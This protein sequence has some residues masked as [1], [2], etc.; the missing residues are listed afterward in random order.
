[1]S[2]RRWSW[3]RARALMERVYPRSGHAGMY[4][5]IDDGRAYVVDDEQGTCDCGQ[6]SCAHRD[7]MALYRYPCGTP[8]LAE[9]SDDLPCGRE[10][11]RLLTIE[12]ARA[13]L[14]EAA[15]R[16]QYACDELGP[17]VL[18]LVAAMEDELE[19]LR[20]RVAWLEGQADTART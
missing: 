17:Q 14:V 10:R 12:H 13:L 20:E 8:F 19:E 16:L 9:L 11:R 3:S 18:A 1:M 15:E 2:Q 4:A 7:A 5:V 6:P